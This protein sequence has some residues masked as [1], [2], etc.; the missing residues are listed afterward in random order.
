MRNFPH[1]TAMSTIEVIQNRFHC[2]IRCD[3]TV[4]KELTIKHHEVDEFLKLTICEP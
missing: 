4:F 1:N 3:L 2:N